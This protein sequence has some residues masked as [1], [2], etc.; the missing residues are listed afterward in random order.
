MVN[1]L[2]E[3]LENKDFED[4]VRNRTLNPPYYIP[5]YQKY[6]N[7]FTQESVPA[8][9]II[10]TFINDEFRRFEAFGSKAQQQQQGQ[11]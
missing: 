8:L 7:S 6:K 5:L 11:Y 9:K 4:W 1:E 10:L 3:K 2:K